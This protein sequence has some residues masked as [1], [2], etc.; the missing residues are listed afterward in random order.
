MGEADMEEG[1]KF[2][3]ELA[4]ARAQHKDEFEVDGKRYPV[5]ENGLQRYTGIKKYGKKGFEALQAAGREGASE[6]EKGR[7]KDQYIKKDDVAEGWEDMVKDAKKRHEQEKGTGKFDSKSISTGTV[8]TRKY[9]AKTGETDDTENV[10]KEKRGRGRPKKS[11]F[12]AHK[13]IDK[14][15]EG[16]FEGIDGSMFVEEPDQVT[17][18]QDHLKQHLGSHLYSKLEKSMRLGDDFPDDLYDN[19]YEY[20]MDE[21]P[22]GTAKGRTGD[23]YQWISDKLNVVF[24]ELNEGRIEG[25]VWTAKPGNVP[26]PMD[27]EGVPAQ[28]ATKT[29][30]AVKPAPTPTAPSS[31]PMGTIKGGVWNAD[32]PKAGEKGVPAPVPVDEAGMEEGNLFTKGLA[33]NDVKV[34]EVIPGT[35]AVK[36]KDIDEALNQMRRIAGLPVVESKAEEKADDDYDN[37]GKVETGKEEYLGSK[38]A[39]AKKAGKLKEGTC[40]SCHKDPCI[41]E[42]TKCME[43]GMYESKCKCDASIEESL[44]QMRRIAGLKE[45]MTHVVMPG[46]GDQEGKMNINTSMDSDGHKSVTITADGNSA[47]ELMQM[48]KLAGVNGDSGSAEQGEPEGV[49]VVSTDDESVDEEIGASDVPQE[50]PPTD[51]STNPPEYNDPTTDDVEEQVEE[52]SRYEANTTPEEHAFPT[53]VLTKG[54]SG[55]FGEKKMHKHGYKNGDNP[56]AVQES[57]TLKLFK[58]Y[59]GIKIKP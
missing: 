21:M 3:D 6:E 59:E 53:Q 14:M 48:L 30:P 41:C 56:L 32:A 57:M 24:P 4:Q 36:T 19:L 17:Y 29:F 51:P 11:Q 15:L 50:D 5:K 38:I 1:N 49:M 35:N 54:G 8:Y 55:D 25:G 31:A 47:L 2:S 46:Q 44:N 40:K 52:D 37:D 39:A 26:A 23:P 34:G 22:Y 13:T 33:D 10:T 42:E 27:P 28:R 20:Y 43:C 9:N 45:C 18:E 12:E 58:E 16:I 7:I